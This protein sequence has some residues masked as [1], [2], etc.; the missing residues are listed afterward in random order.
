MFISTFQKINIPTRNG[1]HTKVQ[2]EKCKHAIAI[3][4]HFS[5]RKD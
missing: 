1:N 2:S 5:V 3:G 4:I